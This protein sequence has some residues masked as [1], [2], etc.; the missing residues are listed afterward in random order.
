MG[1]CH[2]ASISLCPPWNLA[3]RG[4]RKAAAPASDTGPEAEGPVGLIEIPLR[5]RFINRIIGVQ[6]CSALC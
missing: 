6:P 3:T 2:S 1:L 4:R 5:Y